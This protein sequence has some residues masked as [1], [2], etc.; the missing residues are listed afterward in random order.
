MTTILTNAEKD[1]KFSSV[2]LGNKKFL[3][4]AG[5]FAAALRLLEAVG[6][7]RE[8]G[9]GRRVR[10]PNARIRGCSGSGGRRLSRPRVARVTPELFL[11]R[12]GDEPVRGWYLSRRVRPQNKEHG[13]RLRLAQPSTSGIAA[14]GVTGKSFRFAAA[15]R[16]RAA[17]A[18]VYRALRHVGHV[19]ELAFLQRPAVPFFAT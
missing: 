7:E 5:K 9:R 3:R 8:L 16:R 10:A 19:E 2:R 14:P 11:S 15:R 18:R 1:D 6:F 4:T 12:A 13:A 17:G